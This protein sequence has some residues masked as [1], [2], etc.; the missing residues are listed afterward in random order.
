MTYTREQFHSKCF[1]RENNQCIVPWCTK[2]P[3]D[4]HHIIERAE[5]EDGGYF[6]ENGASV[7][8]KHHLMAED[9]T[10]PPQA[11]WYWLEQ[12]PV[13]PKGV[14][15]D[16]NKWGEEFKTPPHKGLRDFHKYPSSRHLMPLYWQG[17]ES[18]AKERLEHDD[19][20]HK[21]IDTFI[22]LEL[23][24]TIKMDGGNTM[25]VK[26]TEHPVRARNGSQANHK[27]YDQLKSLYWDMNL[28]E[29]IPKHCQIFGE[30]TYAKHSIHYGCKGCCKE[31][32]QGPSLGE[33]IPGDW[34]REMY[35]QVF[36]VFNT[37]YNLWL[38]W[39]ETK[40]IAKQI[41]FPTAPVIDENIEFNNEQEA[42]EKLMDVSKSIVDKGHEGIVVRYRNP[43]HYGQFSKRL[44]KY[45]RENHVTG[46]RWEN[47]DIV[48]LLSE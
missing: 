48:N 35:F 28:Y 15:K 29:K 4:A 8:Y 19:T 45:V 43:F 37:K 39:D 24:I 41:G 9:N 12:S 34:G 44:G 11:F 32:N 10:I 25:L 46:G 36:G 38:S 40:I 42:I 14:S 31:R 26:D 21:T 27:S 17:D 13:T 3:V 47:N 20:G 33:I 30:W 22:G 18:L 1:E 5:W 6:P 23:V 2:Q 16:V 7:C